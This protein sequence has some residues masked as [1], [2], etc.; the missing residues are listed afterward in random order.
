MG[1]E[2][3]EIERESCVWGRAG[4]GRNSNRATWRVGFAGHSCTTGTTVFRTSCTRIA[5]GIQRD[6]SRE[7]WGVE[8]LERVEAFAMKRWS[9]AEAARYSAEAFFRQR[10]VALK[11]PWSCALYCWS[12]REAPRCSA[13]AF[14]KQRAEAQKLSRCIAEAFVIER[15]G[16]WEAAGWSFHDTARWSFHDTALK[17][18]WS[19]ALKLFCTSAL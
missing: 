15:W 1:Y 3:T 14:L 8:S 4:V 5:G 6:R 10:A 16:F 17:L 13:E 9:F 11:H 19:R 7:R 18:S 12:F 2:N